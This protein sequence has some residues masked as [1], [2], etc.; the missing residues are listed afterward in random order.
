MFSFL[1]VL[2][3]VAVVSVYA[4][5]STIINPPTV[6]KSVTWAGYG[7]IAGNAGIT[8][9]RASFIQTSINCNPATAVDRHAAFIAALNGQLTNAFEFVGT[10][11]TCPS[12]SVS[13][14]YREFASAGMAPII[15]IIIGHAYLASIL[16]SGGIYHYVLKDVTT[17]MV[18]KGTGGGPNLVFAAECIVYRLLAATGAPL[19]LAH[20]GLVSF[21]MDYSRVPNTCF[22]TYS[23][24][25]KAIWANTVPQLAL[26]KYIMYNAALTTV[27][28][29]PSPITPDKSSFKVA[30]LNSGP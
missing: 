1:L 18:S 10:E 13:P 29:N 28:A 20:F 15:P 16:E 12:G 9:V 4:S 25:T 24:T 7:I 26:V 22:A 21:G 19:P 23:G 17:G 27:D 2:P 3:S 8:A 11:A 30:W 5:S 14:T 6:M